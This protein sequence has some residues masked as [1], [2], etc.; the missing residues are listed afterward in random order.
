[1]ADR[2]EGLRRVEFTLH[3]VELAIDLRQSAF[4]FNQQ[5]P[6]HA[7]GYMV[8]HARRCAMVDIESRHHGFE[9]Y[10]LF[11]AR[12]D[13]GEFRSTPWANRAMKIHGVD[14]DTGRIVL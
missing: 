11:F 1:M 7:V 9:G 2:S 4:G 12:I 6:I 5:K 13:L 10:D 14:H 3:D 8:R